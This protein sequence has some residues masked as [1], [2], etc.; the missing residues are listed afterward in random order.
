[1]PQLVLYKDANFTG[2]QQIIVS[3]TP[4]LGALNFNDSVL[5]IQVKDG[6]WIGY[7]DAD[8]TGQSCPLSPGDYSSVS[9]WDKLGKTISSL[10]LVDPYLVI[11]SGGFLDRSLTSCT[12]IKQS[13]ENLQSLVSSNYP[14]Y[15][16]QETDEYDGILK[17]LKTVLPKMGQAMLNYLSV[18]N[19]ATADRP[20]RKKDFDAA[21]ND[22]ALQ[23]TEWIGF[24]ANYQE[25]LNAFIGAILVE[26]TLMQQKL[27]NQKAEYARLQQKYHEDDDPDFFSWNEVTKIGR[28]ITFQQQDELNS[29]RQQE[30][31]AAIAID[32]LTLSTNS[33]NDSLT[34]L[35]KMNAVITNLPATLSTI[36]SAVGTIES[37]LA[38]QP[39]TVLPMFKRIY[40]NTAIEQWLHLSKSLQ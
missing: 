31:S 2:D 1:M 36:S 24:F 39:S 40:F 26:K 28:I 19:R 14:A 37:K 7:E 3:N 22:A 6:F 17:R 30:E 15:V 18:I 34:E 21:A 27:D 4:N 16:S 38:T 33:L 12:T 5:S 11:I 32:S 8:Y 23:I 29:V 10:Y 9:D 13:L 25:L 35:N 20:Q